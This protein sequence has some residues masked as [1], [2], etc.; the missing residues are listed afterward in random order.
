MHLVHALAHGG[1]SG[2]TSPKVT[3][4]AKVSKVRGVPFQ[5][6]EAPL[7]VQPQPAGCLACHT[8][9]TTTLMLP[10]IPFRKSGETK[11]LPSLSIPASR[12]TLRP[13]AQCHCCAMHPLAAGLADSF[14]CS[15]PTRLGRGLAAQCSAVQRRP[16]PD[17]PTSPRREATTPRGLAAF[18]L[19]WW[20]GS[21]SPPGPLQT[22]SMG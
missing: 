5:R 10:T 8:S 19:P 12:E 20:R 14:I 11:A 21:P 22:N 9:R 1:Q 16:R 13:P 3:R 18:G 7:A 17:Q 4:K 2:Q 15:P 6:D